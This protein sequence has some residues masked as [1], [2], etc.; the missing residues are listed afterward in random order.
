[1]VCVRPL[2]RIAVVFALSVLVGAAAAS[3]RLILV[4]WDG[5][6]D[7]IVD[8]LLA[9][10]HLPN[11]AA[12]A[13]EGVAAEHSITTFPARTA[14]G[15]AAI[16]TGA[17]PVINGIVN[18]AAPGVPRSE[19]TI[20]D[21]Q[22]GFRS[23]LM[24]AEPIY[25]TA[26]RAGRRVAVLSGTHHYPAP[27]IR[28]RLAAAGVPE[29]R[30]RSFS[31]FEYG[32]TPARALTAA[33]FGVEGRASFRLAATDF[34]AEVVREGGRA[35]GVAVRRGGRQVAYLRPFG[36]G[37]GFEAWSEP[38]EIVGAP[39][40]SGEPGRRGNTF[41]RLFELAED[42]SRV[43]LYAR[44][45]AHIGGVASET[46]LEAYRRAYAGFHDEG[47]EVYAAGGFGTTA[48]EG[49]DGTAE[50][51]LLEVAAFDCELLKRSFRFAWRT[52]D[53][54][55]LVHYSPLSDTAAGYWMG[56]MDP[57]SLAYDPER[58]AR[59]WPYFARIYRLLDD[60]IGDMWATAGPDTIFALVS[61]HGMAGMARYVHVNVALERAGLL[62]RGAD[63]RIDL[64][65]TKI[66]AGY[67][68]TFLNVN[69]VDWK[70]GIVPLA[71]RD[72]VIEQAIE[73]LLDLRDPETGR[74]LVRRVW[75]PEEF[76]SLGVGGDR[77]G[78]LYF[79]LETSYMPSRSFA[80][81]LVTRIDPWG[82]GTHVYWPERRNMHAIFY[83][84]GPGLAVGRRLPGI[85]H[86]DIAPTLATAIGIPIPPQAT[87]LAI[88]QALGR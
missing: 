83:A 20:L 67:G 30:F 32:L 86:I 37:A 76:P 8:R 21:T 40:A 25:I 75:R 34:E 9:E 64:S 63:G 3:T 4:S 23:S 72:A 6:A 51:R 35:V 22:R 19:H 87:G 1:M 80:D 13:R 31:G 39:G 61:D 11:V 12:L 60:W 43:L 15:H 79:D 45:A 58:A 24:T 88:G 52:W 71:E 33:D 48:M 69:T 44:R 41:F 42:G 62:A 18:N 50:E 73:V 68:D 7:W 46:D 10:G 81:S 55:V 54:E 36:P 66:A 16:W 74:R 38:V 57:E 14:P 78:D 2:C 28:E 47:F 77:S 53:P 56:L 84:A 26:A 17:W 5:A 59:L 49:G 65:R 70:G 27:A 29:G 82:I 85:R